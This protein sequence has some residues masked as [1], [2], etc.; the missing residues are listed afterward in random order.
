MITEEALLRRSQVLTLGQPSKGALKA[1]T[2]WFRT[3]MPFRGASWHLLDNEE[4]MVALKRDVETDRLSLFINHYFGYFLKVRNVEIP[5]SWESLYYFPAARVEGVSAM[6]SIVL[7][8]LLLLGAILALYFLPASN[9]GK[10]LGVIAV[11][12][13]AFAVS[14]SLLTNAKR[15][16]MFGATAAYVY[17]H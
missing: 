13:I 1:F 5:R 2:G 15:G 17:L 4:D 12:T 8:T 11:F 9:M 3:R 14:I 7:S 16:E 10:R 6:L